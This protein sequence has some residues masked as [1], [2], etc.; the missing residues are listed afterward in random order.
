MFLTLKKKEILYKYNK[1]GVA[2]DVYY[3]P[4]SAGRLMVKH[5]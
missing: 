1:V 5:L 4:P 3:F 2:D